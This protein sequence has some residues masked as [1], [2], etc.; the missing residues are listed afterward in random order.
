MADITNLSNFLGD[1]ASAIREK[2]GTTEP[3]PA[4]EFDSEIATIET[5]T[6]TSDA[7]ATANDI[8]SP[9]TAYVDSGKV[10]GS[11]IPSYETISGAVTYSSKIYDK[12]TSY[13]TIGFV[14]DNSF[15]IEL[16]YTKQALVVRDSGFSIIKEE[17]ISTFVSNYTVTYDGRLY[18]SISVSGVQNNADCHYVC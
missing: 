10:K 9:K 4:Q 1:I 2:K 15:S 6:D 17:P 13:L 5:G 12:G 11:I 3:I 18:I 16:D 14:P 7:T 8:I